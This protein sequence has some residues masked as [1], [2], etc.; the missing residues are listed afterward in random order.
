MTFTLSETNSKFAPENG[1]LEDFLVS[2]WDGIFSG[3]ELLVSGRV[4][5]QKQFGLEVVFVKWVPSR[6]E[7]LLK[8]NS[9]I[10][11]NHD[12]WEKG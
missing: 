8:K 7:S 1:W 3:A 5:F 2:F 4:L 10:F 11:Q 9:R 6:F 12:Y